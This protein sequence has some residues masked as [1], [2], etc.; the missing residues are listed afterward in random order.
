VARFSTPVQTVLGA[1]P[2]SCT[3]G[4]GAASRE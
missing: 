3:M 2:A 4:N 1:H